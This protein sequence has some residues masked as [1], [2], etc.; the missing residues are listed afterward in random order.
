MAGRGARPP[1]P[2][3]CRAGPYPHGKMGAVSTAGPLDHHLAGRRDPMAEEEVGEGE[4][5]ATLLKIS[6]VKVVEGTY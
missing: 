2:T 1:W 6:G 4:N 3:T 5:M